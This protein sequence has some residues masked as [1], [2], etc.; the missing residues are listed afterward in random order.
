MIVSITKQSSGAYDIPP[1]SANV[2]NI[3]RALVIVAGLI[4]ILLLGRRF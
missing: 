3:S 2:I 1:G 4:R